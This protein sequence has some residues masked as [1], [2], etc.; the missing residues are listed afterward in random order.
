LHAGS[1]VWS[2][3]KSVLYIEIRFSHCAQKLDVID[4]RRAAPLD[5]LLQQLRQALLKRR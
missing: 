5:Q 4:A 1:I 3:G 2:F